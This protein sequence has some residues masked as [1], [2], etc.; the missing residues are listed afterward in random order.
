MDN[1]LDICS[2]CLF[3]RSTENIRVRQPLASIAIISKHNNNLKDFEDLIKDAINVKAV[4]YRDDLENYASK[5]LLINFPMLGKRLPHKMKEIIAAS[6]K[7]EWE[8]IAGGLAICGETLNSN[9]YKLVLEPYSHI[10]GA[11]S[12][13]NN[14]SLLILDLELTPEL[15]EEGYARDIVRFIQQARKDAHF[16]ITDRILIEIISEFDLSKII[17]NYRD[18]IKEQTLGEFA[19]NFTPDYVS[20]VELENHQIQLKVK[21]S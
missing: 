17:D 16:S 2:Y 10:K 21:K 15:I 12:F 14:S 1:V 13:E 19:K 7:G 20:K 8:A 9:E 5:K 18:F 4:I 3:I 6:K 11:T